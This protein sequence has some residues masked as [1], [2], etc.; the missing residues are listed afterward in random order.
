MATHCCK[1]LRKLIKNF[2]DFKFS[3]CSECLILDF[4]WLTGRWILRVDVS[5]H[6]VC[7]N[8][9]GSVCK[10]K[11]CY[12][13]WCNFSILSLITGNK[14]TSNCNSTEALRIY[15]NYVLYGDFNSTLHRIKKI[16]S[17]GILLQAGFSVVAAVLIYTLNFWRRIFFQILAHPLFKMWVIQK[18]NKVALWNKRHFEGEKMEIIQHV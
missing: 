16:Y 12:I 1:A 9:I 8:F 14:L 11:L 3:P 10:K 17:K 18:P 4:G 15:L 2:L 5:E 6:T 13:K 7:S